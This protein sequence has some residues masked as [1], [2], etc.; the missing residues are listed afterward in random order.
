MAFN[1]VLTLSEFL[2]QR[3]TSHL[4][5]P[6]RGLKAPII[7]VLTHTRQTLF[8]GPL[9]N[10]CGLTNCMENSC[11]RDSVRYQASHS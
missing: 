5:A 7:Q 2:L 1:N 11:T 8:F 10:I 9:V 3:E 6:L 4:T